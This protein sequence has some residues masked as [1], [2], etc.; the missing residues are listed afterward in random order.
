[1]KKFSSLLIVLTISVVCLGFYRGWFVVSSGR[2]G[3]SNK[4]DVNLTLDPDKVKED[5][6]KVKEKVH[7]LT[8]PVTE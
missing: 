6:G 8:D 4:V 3:V 5:A 1:M 7:E 2:E